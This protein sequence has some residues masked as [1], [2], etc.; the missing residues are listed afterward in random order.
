M[1]EIVFLEKQHIL[2]IGEIRNS[3]FVYSFLR[4]KGL[5][6]PSGQKAWFEKANKDATRK[7]FAILRDGELIGSVLLRDIDIISLYAEAGWFLK[8]SCSGKGYGE[9]AVKLLLQYAFESLGLES[10]YSY[11]YEDNINGIKFVEKIGMKRVG[12][13]RSRRQR[14]SMRIGEYVY[15]MTKDDYVHKIY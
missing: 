8:E 6:T 11:I 5:C 12:L 1:I 14:E 13:L 7:D 10:V 2:K 15:D 4:Q 9:K 3:S